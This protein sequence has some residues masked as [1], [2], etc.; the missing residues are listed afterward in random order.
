MIWR[1]TQRRDQMD[2]RFFLHNLWRDLAGMNEIKIPEGAPSILT[3]RATQWS[4][5]FESC[6]RNRLIIGA[7]RYG[8]MHKEGK[9]KYDRMD[10]IKKKVDKYIETGN[11][12]CLVDIGN[13]ALLEFEEGTHPKKH[14]RSTDDI[15]HCKEVQ[16]IS[17]NLS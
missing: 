16:S 14:F 13:Y 7:L 12:E 10:A 2:G 6:M 3:L 11:D 1:K 17:C 4:P 9:P 5:K 15:S 8:L